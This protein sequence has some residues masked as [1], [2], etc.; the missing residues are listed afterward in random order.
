MAAAFFVGRLSVPER[1]TKTEVQVV[2]K[3]V[4]ET[5]V[6]EVIKEIEKVVEVE[7]ERVKIV[8]VKP[9]GTTI[10]E[11]READRRRHE[12]RKKEVEVQIVEKIVTEIKYE[13]KIVDR[14]ILD[15][16][17]WRVGTAVDLSSALWH[18]R[19]Y[20]VGGSVER[21]IVGPAF[22]GV[23]ANSAGAAGVSASI[24]F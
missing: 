7:K 3:I 1:E 15:K 13:E 19:P 6:R 16:R 22:F 24:E 10:T 4:T 11:E 8:T 5:E 18:D 9:D 21:R 23:W 12:D 20:V 17:D 14:I 2:E